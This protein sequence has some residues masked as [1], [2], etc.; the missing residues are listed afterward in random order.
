MVDLIDFLCGDCGSIKFSASKQKLKFL[1]SQ[2]CSVKK[3]GRCL[4]TGCQETPGQGNTSDEL[5][6]SS[7]R[8]VSFSA[9][10]FHSSTQPTMGVKI[11]SLLAFYSA[12]MIEAMEA[13]PHG[14]KYVLG[15]TAAD[16]AFEA[17]VGHVDATIANRR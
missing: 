17:L 2:M 3:I 16:P 7:A 11:N 1:D 5:S 12:K 4:V 6:F 15:I 9:P 8:V 10:V 13:Q 14:E